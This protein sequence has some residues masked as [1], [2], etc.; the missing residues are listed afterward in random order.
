MSNV[1]ITDKLDIHHNSVVLCLK[2]Y[3]ISGVESA[4]EKP[5]IQAIGN[6]AE[7]LPPTME[8]GFIGRDSEYNRHGTVSL[9]AGMNLI[10]VEMIPLVRETHK[11][12]DFADF[13]QLLEKKYPEAKRNRIILD[14]HGAHP[15]KGTRDYLE[16]HPGR[17]EIVFK[18]KHG[19]C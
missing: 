6:V 12:T 5:G 3:A 17:F 7:D 2:K 16:Q 9:Q 19:S 18:T 13:L 14:N 4:D 10:T 11:S 1:M 8:N 15:S